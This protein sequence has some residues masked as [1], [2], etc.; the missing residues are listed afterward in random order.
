MA[1][2]PASAIGAYNSAIRRLGNGA[3][4]TDAGGDSTT[5][6]G[7]TDFGSM[8]KKFTEDAIQTG[9]TSEKQSIAAAA[10]KADINQVV[11]AVAEAELTL[12]AVTA[13]RD[14]VIEAYQAIIRM[15]M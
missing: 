10:G 11:T 5:P 9:K 1:I 12:N 7:A 3:G 6:T 13:V 8:L 2:D 4:T 15:P 14:K